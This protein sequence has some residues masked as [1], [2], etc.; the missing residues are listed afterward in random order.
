[1]TMTTTR[2]VMHRKTV[3]QQAQIVR[4][5]S[6]GIIAAMRMRVTQMAGTHA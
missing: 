6:K 2:N 5:Q 4:W 3:K 1:M